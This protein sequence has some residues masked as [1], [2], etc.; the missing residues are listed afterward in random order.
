MDAVSNALQ[1]TKYNF[2]YKFIT[3]S[4]HAL[5]QD[6]NSKAAAYICIEDT[7]GRDFWGVGTHDDIILASV[8]ALVSAIN[9]MN[10]EDRFMN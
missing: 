6:S 5:S 8:N 3:Y 10:D 1:K 4:E 9:R 7:N 2:N